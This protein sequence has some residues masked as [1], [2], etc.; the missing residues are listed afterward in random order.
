[1]KDVAFEN[2]KA[3]EFKKPPRNLQLPDSH[4][5]VWRAAVAQT[6]TTRLRLTC[7]LT[8]LE[9]ERANRFKVELSRNQFLVSRGIL[10]SIGAFYCKVPPEAIKLIDR[11]GKKPR[12]QLPGSAPHL[13]FNISHSGRFILIVFARG[14]EVG[15]DLERNRGF[16]DLETIVDRYYSPDE[17]SWL[18]TLSGEHKKE[19]FFRIWTRK[20]AVLKAA[21][22][23]LFQI[24]R[25]ASSETCDGPRTDLH[26]KG[27]ADWIVKQFIPAAGYT[28]AV[29]FSRPADFLD[30]SFQ[31]WEWTGFP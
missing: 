19:G 2:S 3:V 29:A 18:A 21:G 23:G 25:P 13:D 5:H 17:K 1:V 8:D 30:F 24:D 4:V 9:L 26:G 28:A 12:I 20:E 15:I 31:F 6:K 16:P 22:A 7:L 11:P 10:R 14:V 27:K